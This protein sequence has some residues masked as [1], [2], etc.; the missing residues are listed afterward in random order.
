MRA[1]RVSDCAMGAAARRAASGRRHPP[2]PTPLATWSTAGRGG[3]VPSLGGGEREHGRL[4]PQ[5]LRSRDPRHPSPSPRPRRRCASDPRRSSGTRHRR[6]GSRARDGRRG[7]D[8]LH[9]G[10]YRGMTTDVP[11]LRRAT[12]RLTASRSPAALVELASGPD[13][14]S[15]WSGRRCP[16]QARPQLVGDDLHGRAGAAVLGGPGPLLDLAQDHDPAALG[17]RLGRVLGLVPPHDHGIER[18]GGRHI[19]PTCSFAG[20]AYRSHDPSTRHPSP[21]R[22]GVVASAA[23]SAILRQRP[24]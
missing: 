9:V 22:L 17:Q 14:S 3:R 4:P 16:A 20:P 13:S 12:A 5:D 7:L 18:S 6:A 10:R 23:T 15:S 19:S 2:L 21:L 8:L 24:R 1:L 11:G